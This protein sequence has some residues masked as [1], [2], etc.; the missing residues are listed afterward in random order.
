[1]RIR[2]RYPQSTTL[3]ELILYFAL[4]SIFL[5]AAFQ[6]AIQMI[7]ISRLSNNIQEVEMEVDFISEKMTY[8][9]SVASG[10]DEV[11]S[12]FDQDQGALSLYVPESSQSPTRFYLS[13]GN[14]FVTEGTGAPF[15]LNHD[16]VVFDFL[17]FHRVSFPKA[18]DQIQVEGQISPVFGQMTQL[19]HPV[20]FHFTVSLRY[21][22]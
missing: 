16:E 13:N 19:D 7:N 14:V 10:I 1:M 3:L 21:Y 2:P 15:Q 8:I 11:Q 20:S 5:A 9:I 12:V 6:F 17:R 22:P 18:P 4:L